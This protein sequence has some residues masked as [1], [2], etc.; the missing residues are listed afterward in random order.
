MEQQIKEFDSLLE[1]LEYLD[2][3][4]IQGVQRREIAMRYL[5]L[6]ARTLGQAYSGTFELTPLCNFDCKMC[7]VHLSQEQM[8]KEGCLLSTEQWISIM[9]QAADA[10]MM[11]AALTGGECLSYPGFKDIYLYLQSRGISTSI[12]TNGQLITEEMADFFAEHPPAVVQ[13]T[14]YGSNE[15]AYE[16][17]T[18]HRAFADVAN[19]IQRLKTRGVNLFLPVTPNA[20]MQED[21]HELLAFLRSLDVRYGIGTGSLPARPSTGRKRETY[22]PDVSLYVRLHADENEYQRSIHV[23]LPQKG[24]VVP[25]CIPSNYKPISKIACSAGQAA[26]HINWKGEMS[27]CI[28]YYTVAVSV[29]ENGFDYAWKWIKEKMAAYEPP[30][31][32]VNCEIASKCSVCSAEKTLSILNGSLNTDVCARYKEYIRCGIVEN[33]EQ[34]DCN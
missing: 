34:T 29:L 22:A 3:Q 19:A 27:P 21:T 28:P 18:G 15:D 26:Y 25:N 9:K 8:K 10:G 20:Y 11:H 16:K 6:R 31:Q 1:L 24:T 33:T 14:L 23:D 13:I 32:C 30:K 5:N 4:G 17:V 2:D 12:L 7:Y